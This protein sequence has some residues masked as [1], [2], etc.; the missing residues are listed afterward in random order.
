MT[1]SINL[2]SVSN[3]TFKKISEL[4]L[5]LVNTDDYLGVCYF[6]HSSYKHFGLRDTTIAKRKRVHKAMMD[7]GLDVTHKSDEHSNIITKI[8]GAKK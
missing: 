2:N 4:D 8:I 3:K 5:T 1:Y 6:W 7:N